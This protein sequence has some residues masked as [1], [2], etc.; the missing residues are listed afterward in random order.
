MNF[1]FPELHPI[2]AHFK[3][4]SFLQFFKRM[5]FWLVFF[6]IALSL[7]FIVYVQAEKKL[8]VSHQ[9]RIAFLKE[10]DELRR[11]SDDL[12]RMAHGA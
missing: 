12:T 8:S 3:D 1:S 5:V 4:Y 2:M 9:S 6:L 11:T 10:A 7:Q